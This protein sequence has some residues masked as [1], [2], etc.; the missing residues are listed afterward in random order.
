MFNRR[1]GQGQYERARGSLTV[2]DDFRMM[3]SDENRPDQRRPADQ[4]E[5][6]TH[7]SRE[8]TPSTA[9]AEGD[10][11]VQRGMVRSGTGLHTAA[12]PVLFEIRQV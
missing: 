7:A 12:G 5:D 8:R 4:G 11:P 10:E 2:G 1:H 3:D 6:G 9:S